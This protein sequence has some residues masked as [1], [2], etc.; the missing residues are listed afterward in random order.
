MWAKQAPAQAVHH[1]PPFPLLPHPADASSELLTTFYPTLSA[2]MLD[3]M[4]R[5]AEAGEGGGGAAAEP[6]KLWLQCPAAGSCV[7]AVPCLPAS[8]E[9]PGRRAAA[10]DIQVCPS[11]R[12]HPPTRPSDYEDAYVQQLTSLLP[13]DE[14]MRKI[15][16]VCSWVGGW[17][18]GFAFLGARQGCPRMNACASCRWQG[19]Y[20]A[21]CCQCWGVA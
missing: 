20:P 21:V 1:F 3:A 10:Q 14:L 18:A 2:I 9:E 6:G 4:L 15:T 13:K 5:Q 7:R 12:P 11:T 17:E 19:S 16:Q 8:A